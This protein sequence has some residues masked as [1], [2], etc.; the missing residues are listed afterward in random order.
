MKKTILKAVE[1]LTHTSV[2][3]ANNTASLAWSYEPKAPADIK[4][5]DSKKTEK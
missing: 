2:K 5:F 3:L 4:K 1:K